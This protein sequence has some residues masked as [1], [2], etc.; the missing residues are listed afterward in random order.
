[1]P[2]RQRLWLVI[3]ALALAHALL[4]LWFASITPYRTAG[5]IMHNPAPDIGAPDE[6][7]HANYVQQLLDGHGIPTLDID[8]MKSDSTYRAEQYESHQPPLFYLAEFAWAKVTGVSDVSDPSAGLRLRALNALFGAATVVGVFFAA[9]WG[10]KRLD[11]AAG[12][13]L[14][15]ALL[16]MSVA[17]S[18]AVSNDPLLFALIAWTM[19]VTCRALREGWT[20]KL[21]VLAGALTGAAILTKTTGVALLPVLLVGVLVPQLK[22]PSGRMV[23]AAVVA[24]SVISGPWLARN[25]SV[26]HD[27]LGRT[28][29]NQAFA[30]TAHKELI[31]QQS[32]GEGM[33]YWTNWVA[34]WTARSFV[35]TFGYMD[36]FLNETGTMKTESGT[37]PNTLYRVSLA[38]LALLSLGWIKSLSEPWS[39]EARAVTIANAT[40]VV[41]VLFLFLSFNNVFF[42]GQARYVYPAMSA[43]AAGFASGAV[44][45]FAKKPVAGIA[46]VGV[47]LLGL[48]VYAGMRLPDEFAQRTAPAALSNGPQPAGVQ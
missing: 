17:L 9:Y 18:G 13:A 31:E 47:L 14:F 1:M 20:V 24:V 3:G 16:P 46:A 19:A 44:A 2:T 23:L 4:A 43:L 42:Q 27:P 39:R 34:W 32:G 45:W 33:G 40:L 25:Q 8:R 35:G 38:V 48:C 37:A 10:F 21:A 30:D 5:L 12:A 6:R 7:A 41:V 28:L 22:R 26:Y 29:F 36:V 15:P 11:L